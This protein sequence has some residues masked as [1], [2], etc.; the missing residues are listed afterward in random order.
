MPKTLIF[1]DEN[2]ETY[3][4]NDWYM[5][6]TRDR[7]VILFYHGFK[8]TL[9]CTMYN[10]ILAIKKSSSVCDLREWYSYDKKG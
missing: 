9:P 1:D 4:V 3:V 5:K 10:A 2:N 8:I 6:E 7:N